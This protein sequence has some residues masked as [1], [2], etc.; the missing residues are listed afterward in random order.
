MVYFVAQYS[1]S[2]T[3]FQFLSVPIFRKVRG[4][5]LSPAPPSLVMSVFLSHL[6]LPPSTH[7]LSCL[8]IADLLLV[9]LS[10]S[11]ILLLSFTP[12][13]IVFV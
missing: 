7:P 2:R 11:M 5:P 3:V 4:P 10:Y 12:F 1:V 6:K 9:R 13:Q 8:E